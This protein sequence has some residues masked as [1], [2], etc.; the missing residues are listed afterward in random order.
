MHGSFTVGVM[1]TSVLMARFHYWLQY[2][3]YPA[4]SS[5]NHEMSF[6]VM[7]QW[8]IIINNRLDLLRF[9]LI[10]YAKV[11]SDFK[12]KQL[13]YVT[14]GTKVDFYVFVPVL[15]PQRAPLP[16]ADFCSDSNRGS[17]NIQHLQLRPFCSDMPR[18]YWAFV[19]LPEK[20]QN[21]KMTTSRPP[22][23]SLRNG[24]RWQKWNKLW[25]H[26]KRYFLYST[27]LISTG[28]TACHYFC[29]I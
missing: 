26:R 13:N 12:I 7:G 22:H 20:C 6:L 24:E 19:F 3:I 25:Q 16:I 10:L 14:P 17:F 15:T 28:N 5:V 29:L 18:N 23:V 27:W 11:I 4:T 2:L 8:S 9:Q 21:E 1:W